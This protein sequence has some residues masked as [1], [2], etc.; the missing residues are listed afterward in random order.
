MIWSDVAD[1]AV[2]DGMSQSVE[3]KAVAE[4]ATAIGQ[5]L[6]IVAGHQLQSGHQFST[7]G[8]ACVLRARSY[9]LSVSEAL[10]REVRE[11]LEETVTKSPDYAEAHAML[12]W[13]YLEEARN[14]FNVRMTPENALQDA[15]RVAHRAIELAPNSATAHEAMMA[16]YDRLGD[17]DAAF[18]AGRHAVELNPN[19][20]SCWDHWEPDCLPEDN[21]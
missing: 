12:A 2:S 7:G 3:D 17:F 10:H 21:G 13:I 11:C 20:P 1:H 18:A 9:F 14:D 16:I 6:G 4:V 15:L 19:N 5:P 8:Y